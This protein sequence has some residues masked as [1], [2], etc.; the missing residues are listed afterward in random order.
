MNSS[1]ADLSF[2]FFCP[3][4]GQSVRG[5]AQAGVLSHLGY[6]EN[7]SPLHPNF[8][9]IFGLKS[10]EKYLTNQVQLQLY[11]RRCCAVKRHHTSIGVITDQRVKLPWNGSISDVWWRLM[12][13]DVWSVMRT[14]SLATWCV[15]TS[16]DMWW[17]RWCVMTFVDVIWRT[18]QTSSRINW[19]HHAST[20]VI[21]HQLTSS[22]IIKQTSSHINCRHHRSRN[23]SISDCTT[24]VY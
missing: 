2:R 19:R 18:S 20:D 21:T 12:R 1:P 9:F 17:R 8:N 11:N 10:I 13:V 23:G 3:N 24:K 7:S 22:R 16:V 6:W 15:M 4:L 5:R 14:D